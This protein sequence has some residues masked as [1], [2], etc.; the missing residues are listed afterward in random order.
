MDSLAVGDLL[1]AIIFL[2]NGFFNSEQL[3]CDI[4]YRDIPPFKDIVEL[5]QRCGETFY[6]YYVNGG[7]RGT[8]SFKVDGIM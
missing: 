5:L 6:S 7:L 3:S 1:T 8:I 4:G 2:F